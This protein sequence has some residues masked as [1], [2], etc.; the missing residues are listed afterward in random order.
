MKNKF[1]KPEVQF[2]SFICNE[3]YDADSVWTGDFDDGKDLPLGPDGD[4]DL[5][6]PD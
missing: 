1:T 4:S 3:T 6:I 2:L 5:G